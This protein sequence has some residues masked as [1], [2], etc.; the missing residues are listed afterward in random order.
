MIARYM[1]AKARDE[2]DKV[3]IKTATLIKLVKNGLKTK[4][5]ARCIHLLILKVIKIEEFEK[6]LLGFGTV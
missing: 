3:W 2:A 4:N 5:D 6:I 1:L